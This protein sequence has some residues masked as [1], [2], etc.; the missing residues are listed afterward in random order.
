MTIAGLITGVKKDRGFKTEELAAYA[1]ISRSE[2][3]KRMK[4]PKLWRLGELN[5]IYRLLKIKEEERIYKDE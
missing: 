1:G 5:S 2:F 4:N 3:F